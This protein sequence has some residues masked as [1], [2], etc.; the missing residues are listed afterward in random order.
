M[1]H[2]SILELRMG[3]SNQAVAP[4]ITRP[5][6]A[7]EYSD[8]WITMIHLWCLLTIIII[9]HEVGRAAATRLENFQGKRKVSQE[10]WMTK[11][12]YSIQWI[13]GKRRLLKNP[14]CK[15]CIQRCEN[16]Q[17]KRKLPK[18]LNG[19]IYIQ[20]S[21]IFQGTLCFSGQKRKLLKNLERWKN[22]Q[23]SVF[24]VYSLGGDPCN[25]W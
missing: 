4:G 23:Y 7:T 20:Y 6:H 18:I 24:S 19:R 17:R 13:Q 21:E 5:L 15:K 11:N 3:A 1:R 8:K 2:C 25:L 14:E 9:E 12:I 16:F 22:F 10:S